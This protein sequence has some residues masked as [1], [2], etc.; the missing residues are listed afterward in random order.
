[1]ETGTVS[2]E[3]RWW[4]TK[5]WGILILAVI[6]GLIIWGITYPFEKAVPPSEA[7]NWVV[8]GVVADSKT[9]ASLPR[10]EVTISG[11]TEN[12]TTDDNGNFRIELVGNLPSSRTLRVRITKA[13]Y[14]ASDKSVTVPVNDL[15]VLLEKD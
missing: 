6:S 15:Y 9:N 11:R 8:A 12:S 13:G 2:K 10:A 3:K 7:S 4:E 14:K 1:M 5:W